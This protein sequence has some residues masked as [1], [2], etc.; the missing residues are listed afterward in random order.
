[1]LISFICKQCSTPPLTFVAVTIS[2]FIQFTPAS[3]IVPTIRLVVPAI[4]VFLFIPFLSLVFILRLLL[5]V[6][7]VCLLYLVLHYLL[8]FVLLLLI[9]Q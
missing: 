9:V 5:F 7:V 6:V 8:L 2:P 4:P 1:M 3:P